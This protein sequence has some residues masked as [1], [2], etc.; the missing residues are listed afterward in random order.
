MSLKISE[1]SDGGSVQPTDQVPLVRAGLNYR[2]Q[3]PATTNDLSSLGNTIT[4]N[5]NGISDTA[6]AVNSV[7]GSYSGTEVTVTVNDV[8]ATPFNVD[9]DTILGHD[10]ANSI[11]TNTAAYNTAIANIFAAIP[12]PVASLAPYIV[13]TTGVSEY[14]TIDDAIAQ[15]VIDGASNLTPKL[16]LV[17]PGSYSAFTLQPGIIV[18]A[19]DGLSESLIYSPSNP[20]PEKLSVNVTGPILT[21]GPTDSFYKI[22]GINIKAPAS[23]VGIMPSSDSFLYLENCLA[24]T[25]DSSSVFLQ[26]I[27]AGKFFFSNVNSVSAAGSLFNFAQGGTTYLIIKNGI[28]SLS[29][30][31]THSDGNLSLVTEN[32]Q[33]NNTGLNFSSAGG[34]T[35]IGAT[36]TAF[37][38]ITSTSASF[39]AFITGGS[40]NNIS[41]TT[42]DTVELNYTK[43]LG[44]LSGAANFVKNFVYKASSVDIIKK[45]TAY[46]GT[47]LS[48][49][50]AVTTTTNATPTVIVGV[51]VNE[52][53][54]IL[55]TGIVTAQDSANIVSVGGTF[56]ALARRTGAGAVT[57][58]GSPTVTVYSDTTATFIISALTTTLDV[59]VTG[60]LA[61]TYNWS[62]VFEY[63]RILTN[64]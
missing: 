40:V 10:P 3:I 20:V 47:G 14:S 54:T 26:P 25:S 9:G 24:T 38:A 7:S 36:N 60:E 48:A 21:S 8:A 34:Y 55:V 51:P 27:I 13:G 22:S 41:S 61:T 46:N 56:S 29:N 59:T 42:A 1:M 19:I 45:V 16:I 15:A 2:G 39:S 6:S 53:E 37:S 35:F 17:K 4:S 43:L 52:N 58:V 63:Q 12:A 30:S 23:G 49:S 57:I 32:C 64:A 44:T 5:V 62:V 50:Q 11:S 31:Y 28:F 33:F 18:K